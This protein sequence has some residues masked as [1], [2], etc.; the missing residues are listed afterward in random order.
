MVDADADADAST[1]RACKTASDCDVARPYCK[2]ATVCSECMKDDDCSAAGGIVR[3]R[4]GK[5]LD[6]PNRC[7]PCQDDYDCQSDDPMAPHCFD[8]GTV[9]V[10]VECLSD[11]NCI[12]NPRL[13]HCDLDVHACNECATNADCADPKKPLCQPT[14]G[15]CVEC[16]VDADCKDGKKPKCTRSVCGTP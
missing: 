12:V 1:I 14:Y 10:C 8:D 9:T 5:T 3:C 4:L 15:D 13:K 11:A 2:A 6:E 16:V 7:V